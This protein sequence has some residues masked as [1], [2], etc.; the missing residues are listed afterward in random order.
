MELVSNLLGLRKRKVEGGQ[1]GG[2]NYAEK[3]GA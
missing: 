1:K 3:E 2:N